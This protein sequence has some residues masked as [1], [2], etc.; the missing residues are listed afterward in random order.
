[1]GRFGRAILEAIVGGEPDP[2]RL[3]DLASARFRGKISTI[4]LGTGETHPG[5]S[6]VQPET[7][8]GSSE[9]SYSR[10]PTVT[11]RV[12]A[13]GRLGATPLFWELDVTI[14]KPNKY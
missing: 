10:T 12:S 5:A 14:F 3:A 9:V 13:R 6:S 1:M 4:A 11:E 7:T 2:V 8:D